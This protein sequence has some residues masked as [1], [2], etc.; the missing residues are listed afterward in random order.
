MEALRA[1]CMVASPASPHAPTHPSPTP[2]TYLPTPPG[3][4]P[5]KLIEDL[6]KRR[7]IKT[8]GVSM[9]QGQEVIARR[10]MATAAAE[11]HW[12]L[13][14]NAHLGMGYLA[15][16]RLG[17]REGCREGCGLAGGRR[18]GRLPRGCPAPARPPPR[19][20]APSPSLTRRWSSSWP[21]PTAS[22]PLWVTAEPHPAFPIGLLQAR[23]S[24]GLLR[25]CCWVPLLCWAQLLAGHSRPATPAPSSRRPPRAA[26]GA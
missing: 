6:A 10:H 12:V 14:Q 1:D 26:D 24:L 21:R 20:P 7:K 3:A 18:Q 19:C 4:D 13:L 25:A 16:A 23:G 17:C 15:E 22:T 5:T 11:G 8:L 2:P 9:G